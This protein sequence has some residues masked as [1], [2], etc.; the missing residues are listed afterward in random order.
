MNFVSYKTLPVWLGLILVTMVQH[1]VDHED[2]SLKQCA[3]HHLVVF[4]TKIANFLCA[5]WIQVL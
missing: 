4:R 5:E 3:H 2:A 1:N